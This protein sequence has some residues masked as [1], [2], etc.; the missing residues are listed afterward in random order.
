MQTSLDKQIVHIF[1][2]RDAYSHAT[3][4]INLYTQ[5]KWMFYENVIACWIPLWKSGSMKIWKSKNWN[6]YEYYF[7][8]P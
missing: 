2:Y 7:I 1:T 5:D 4:Y 3:L 8:F 6:T